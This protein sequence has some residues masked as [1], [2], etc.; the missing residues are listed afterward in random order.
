[1]IGHTTYHS[2]PG[3][4]KVLKTL[5]LII[6]ILIA[7][8]PG[9][10][11]IESSDTDAAQI[12]ELQGQL[13]QARKDLDRNLRAYLLPA[14]LVVWAALFVYVRILDKKQRALEET[15]EDLRAR[16]GSGE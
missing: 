10:S 2:S 13:N 6:L 3:R 4:Q 5:S 16:M 12:R 7:L 11:Q 1:M 14:F 8:P 9:W 15:L